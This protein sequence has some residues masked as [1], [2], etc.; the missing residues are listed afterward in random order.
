M[1]A[2]ALQ[3]MGVTQAI[4]PAAL[5]E[6]QVAALLVPPWHARLRGAV[7]VA[8]LA[9]LRVRVLVVLPVPVHLVVAAPVDPQ[10][11]V[12]LA[13]SLLAV[14]LLRVLRAGQVVLLEQAVLPA[15]VVPVGPAGLRVAERRALLP[16][17]ATTGHSTKRPSRTS[18]TCR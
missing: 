14:R 12:R 11:Q 17:V 1:S 3:L 5:V 16:V 8:A 2:T 9:V 7:A 15:Q 13:V 10:V 18:A 4:K 6:R